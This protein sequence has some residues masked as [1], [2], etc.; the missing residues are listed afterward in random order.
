M[1]AP[2]AA[3]ATFPDTS[4]KPRSPAGPG[5]GVGVGCWFRRLHERRKRRGRKTVR[6]AFVLILIGRTWMVWSFN[7]A[8]SLEGMQSFADPSI[9]FLLILFISSTGKT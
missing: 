7:P 1:G 4:P 3:S 2:V 9:S 6:K 5:V 8:T